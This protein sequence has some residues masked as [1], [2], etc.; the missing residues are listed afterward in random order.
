MFVSSFVPSPPARPERRA[1]RAL[2]RSAAHLRL[3][4]LAALALCFLPRHGWAQG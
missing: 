2:G 4:A 1:L 3:F